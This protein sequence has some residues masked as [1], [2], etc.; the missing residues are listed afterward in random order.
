M[1]EYY[2]FDQFLVISDIFV[3]NPGDVS[4]GPYSLRA[5]VAMDQLPGAFLEA[6]NQVPPYDPTRLRRFIRKAGNHVPAEYDR[7]YLAP[8]GW[9]Q[10]PPT[11]KFKVARRTVVWDEELLIISDKIPPIVYP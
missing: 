3:S 4:T 11:A 9:G 7:E 5:A 6:V 10:F 8:A 1:S 2:C